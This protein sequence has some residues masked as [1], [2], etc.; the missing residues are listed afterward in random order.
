MVQG[1]HLTPIGGGNVLL[2]PT[3]GLD[4]NNP[5][6]LV[7]PLLHRLHAL[8]ARRLLYDLQTIPL[9]DPIYY[10]WLLH[11]YRACRVAGVEMVTVN[12]QPTAAYGLAVTLEET[13]PFQC[14]LDVDAARSLP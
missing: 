12:M 8:A 7:V 5:D 9:I 4:P 2:E 6:A 13:P 14:A 1:V 10:G 11:V 3:E